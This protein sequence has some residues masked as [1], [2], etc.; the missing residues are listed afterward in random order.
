SGYSEVKPD[1]DGILR[2]SDSFD[3]DKQSFKAASTLTHKFSPR[4]TLQ[5]GAIYTRHNFDFLDED[6][7]ASDN[8]YFIV[9]DMR[10]NADQYQGFVS[11]KYR[12]LEKLTVVTGLHAQGVSLDNEV[13]IEPRTSVRWQFHPLQAFTAGFG[14]HGKMESLPNY[15]AIVPDEQGDAQ[16]PNR[17]LGLSKAHHYVLG[18]ERKVT[19]NLFLKLEE[20]GRASCRERVE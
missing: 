7:E 5:A 11:W 2:R 6:Y 12:P 18:Y 4:H 13:S 14:V 15:Y 3:M 8:T 19:A 10:G 17:N 20:I 16:M 1:I 9:Q